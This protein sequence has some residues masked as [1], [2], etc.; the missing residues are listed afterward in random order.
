[1]ATHVTLNIDK[2]IE[3]ILWMN[4]DGQ[5]LKKKIGITE[6]QMNVLR[7]IGRHAR[8][9]DGF[10]TSLRVALNHAQKAKVVL[11]T[12][13]LDM[14]ASRTR[15]Q[16]LFDVIKNGYSEADAIQEARQDCKK[17]QIERNGCT[18]TPS[19]LESISVRKSPRGGASPV[20]IDVFIEGTDNTTSS[21]VF[22]EIREIRARAVKK[23][24]ATSIAETICGEASAVLQKKGL[25]S[26]FVMLCD[27]TIPF[28]K[29]LATGR[30]AVSFQV[31]R[32]SP[33]WRSLINIQASHADGFATSLADGTVVWMGFAKERGT[34]YSARIDVWKPYIGE[35]IHL[36]QIPDYSTTFIL[37]FR[38]LPKPIGY[39]NIFAEYGVRFLCALCGVKRWDGTGKKTYSQRFVE[40]EP[41]FTRY[42][43]FEE[44]LDS[45][46]DVL[47]APLDDA[48]A[49]HHPGA[50]T[51]ENPVRV[52]DHAVIEA[53]ARARLLGNQLIIKLLIRMWPPSLLELGVSPLQVRK[54][55][56]RGF[57][58]SKIDPKTAIAHLNTTQARGI[59]NNLQ[60]LHPGGGKEVIN[61]IV[62]L[63]KERYVPF[64]HGTAFLPF[65]QKVGDRAEVSP[66]TPTQEILI[67][68]ETVAVEAMGLTRRGIKVGKLKRGGV[69]KHW[70]ALH[71]LLVGDPK[72]VETVCKAL[73]GLMNA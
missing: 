42:K 5:M 64:Y 62:G 15:Q 53:N 4:N 11:G 71:G 31:L 70:N 57:I 63:M 51:I 46:H 69:E 7:E 38:Q 6:D 8:K 66:I 34:S 22:T 72:A 32:F 37:E 56:E 2:F 27:L 14:V 12:Q 19:H 16:A 28:W 9:M 59:L 36:E 47:V 33:S 40:H 54:E 30:L 1:M 43:E 52:P 10:L 65:T 21:V 17:Y 48:L 20:K 44:Y 68:L 24:C 67:G 25:L 35:R 45:I 61:H 49:R 41:W 58:D 23:G 60:N 50:Q 13:F 26:K 55:M 29:H 39:Y 3:K 73:D 18:F